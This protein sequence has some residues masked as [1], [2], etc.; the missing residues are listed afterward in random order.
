M[1]TGESDDLHCEPTPFGLSLV[2]TTSR[3]RV[4]LD[5]DQGIRCLQALLDWIGIDDVMTVLND[6]CRAKGYGTWEGP[7]VE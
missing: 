2:L 5:A 4:M 7:D 3:G 1:P 6:W